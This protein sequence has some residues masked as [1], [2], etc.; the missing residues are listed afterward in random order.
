MIV[1]KEKLGEGDSSRDPQVMEEGSKL[2]VQP[3]EFKTRSDTYVLTEAEEWELTPRPF[4]VWVDGVLAV[5][6]GEA[7]IVIL[8]EAIEL[9]LFSWRDHPEMK[10][11]CTIFHFML[12]ANTTSLEEVPV[13]VFKVGSLK[14]RKQSE[15]A[16]REQSIA[17]ELAAKDA[18][19]S[20][21][22]EAARLQR[23]RAEGDQADG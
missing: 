19:E 2:T 4:D 18:R 11:I 20:A 5:V 1:I 21:I 8:E 16:D 7:R 6:S 9:P 15:I 13:T 17:K 14:A 23:E 3:G 10:A 22:L 12:P